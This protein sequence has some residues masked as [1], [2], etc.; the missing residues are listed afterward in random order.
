MLTLG[1]MLVV[2]FQPNYFWSFV[3]S[4]MLGVL[5]AGF[6]STVSTV[7]GKDYKGRLEAY[8]LFKFQQCLWTCLPSLLIMFFETRTFLYIM[9][10]L[11]GLATVI[12]FAYVGE[13]EE[14]IHKGLTGDV[15]DKI[16]DHGDS[17]KN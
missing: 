4:C 2:S 16:R 8:S 3:P 17:D 5:E 9:I 7:L 12:L 11:S 14:G 10:G 15:Y 6:N 13:P 1:G